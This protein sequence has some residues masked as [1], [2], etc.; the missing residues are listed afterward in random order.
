MSLSKTLFLLIST[1]STREDKKS[2]GNGLKT[3]DWDVNH[4]NKQSFGLFF[5]MFE[6]DCVH[7]L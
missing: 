1:G 6:P 7:I 5:I 3:V 2:T 4:Q